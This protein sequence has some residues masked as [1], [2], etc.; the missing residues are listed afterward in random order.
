VTD[1]LDFQFPEN[2]D[3]P[4]GE[5]VGASADLAI[6]GSVPQAVCEILTGFGR[7]QVE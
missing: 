6:G 7:F 1:P 4:V 2:L 3:E 5:L